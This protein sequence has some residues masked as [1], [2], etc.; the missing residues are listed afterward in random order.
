M[1]LDY[2]LAVGGMISI[3]AVLALVTLLWE[4]FW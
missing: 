2:I 1:I 4:M 3:F